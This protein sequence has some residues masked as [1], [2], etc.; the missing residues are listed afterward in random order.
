MRDG[1]LVYPNYF[2]QQIILSYQR[3]LN[4]FT[5]HYLASLA[6]S[7]I[8]L[9][10]RLDKYIDEFSKRNLVEIQ[11]R[12]R[13]QCVRTQ[14]TNHYNIGP[15]QHINVLSIFIEGTNAWPSAE[16]KYSQTAR[17]LGNRRSRD[18]RVC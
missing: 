13:V 1:R 16:T 18:S 7:D 11:L 8:Q 14:V 17:R 2:W 9:P 10:T 4:K 6:N 5:I 3:L 15:I 12:G